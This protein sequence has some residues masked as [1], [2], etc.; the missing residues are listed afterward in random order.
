MAENFLLCLWY[1][2]TQQRD[3]Y[4]RLFAGLTTEF[5]NDLKK[6]YDELHVSNGVEAIAV[7]VRNRIIYLFSECERLL[8]T[9]I[10]T[11]T[12]IKQKS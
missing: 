3:E 11:K 5:R 12:I 1:Q 9:Y 6:V 10:S 8:Y 7:A 2:L 4:S